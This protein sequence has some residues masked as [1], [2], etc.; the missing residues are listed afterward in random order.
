MSKVP[1]VTVPPNCCA[2][3]SVNMGGSPRL[4]VICTGKLANA[5]PGPVLLPTLLVTAFRTPTMPSR[6]G[7]LPKLVRRTY[8]AANVAVNCADV[9][10]T[11][12][13]SLKSAPCH[14]V[15]PL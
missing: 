13:V 12:H 6:S 10:G 9:P 4:E 8:I 14:P 3:H 11:L 5:G 15:P 7:L 1:Q 2:K